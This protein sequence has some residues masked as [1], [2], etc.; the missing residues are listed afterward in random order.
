MGL[1]FDWVNP[2]IGLTKE[3]R[4][5]RSSKRIT[6][7]KPELLLV[8]LASDST[9]YTD[10]T[11]PVNTVSHY[12]LVFVLTDE[13][14]VKCPNQPMGYFPDGTGP[15]SP[16][17]LTGDWEVGYFGT[18]PVSDLYG[19]DELRAALGTASL[20]GSVVGITNAKMTLWYKF[21]FEGKII[22]VPQGHMVT[23]VKWCDIYNK[24]LMFGTDGPGVVKVTTGI[25][26]PVN[27]RVALT[28]NGNTYRVRTPKALNKPVDAL[29]PGLSV[30]A[31]LIGSEWESIVSASF[32]TNYQ[33]VSPT[34]VGRLN[35][36]TVGDVVGYP[37]YWMSITQHAIDAAGQSHS[38]GNTGY[39]DT[40]AKALTGPWL[41]FL[42]LEFT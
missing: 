30:N 36:F 7:L 6:E 18:L 9:T 3:T 8:T 12:C 24:G 38:R 21:V 33:T 31:D 1:K 15:G 40:D 14:L 11:P 39:P 26:G 19:A 2:N 4:V 37:L 41:P 17:P 13:T 32:I 25:S 42:E 23:G 29:Y 20:P 27:Q 10:S 28:K 35:S 22:F 16:T 5:Y 34:G